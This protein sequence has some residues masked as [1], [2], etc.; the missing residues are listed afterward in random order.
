MGGHPHFSEIYLQNLDPSSLSKYLRKI[1]LCLLQGWGK[2][3]FFNYARALCSGH[4]GL[5]SGEPTTSALKELTVCKLRDNFN[6]SWQ[7]QV[8]RAQPAG[9]YQNLTDLCGEGKD[10][11][12]QYPCLENPMDRGAWQAAVHGVTR[13]RHDLATKLPQLT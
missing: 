1:P 5:L 10:N 11:S 6:I 13:V 9:Y 12:L 7:V 4:Q 8:T 3:P 2:E